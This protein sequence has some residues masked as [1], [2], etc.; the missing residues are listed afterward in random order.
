M[1]IKNLKLTAIAAVVGLA[2]GGTVL[3]DTFTATATVSNTITVTE[4]T[5][6]SFGTLAVIGGAAADLAPTATLTVPSDGTIPDQI[7]NV[8]QGTNAKITIISG[9]TPGVLQISGAA[10]DSA[11]SIAAPVS[12]TLVHPTGPTLA[13]TPEVGG[14]AAAF[15]ATTT[16]AAGE[17]TL[18]VGGALSTQETVTYIDGTYSGTYEVTLSY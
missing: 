3:A 15:G 4:T 5:P 17:L 1:K 6:L 2:T 16:D 8:S 12:T 14:A 11:I 9:V 10:A 18:Y 13:F 7:N